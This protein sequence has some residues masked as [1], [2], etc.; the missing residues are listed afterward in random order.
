MFHLFKHRKA[1]D[2]IKEQFDNIEKEINTL[3]KRHKSFDLIR[4]GAFIDLIENNLDRF[5]KELDEFAEEE[6]E[7]IGFR[8]AFD[9]VINDTVIKAKVLADDLKKS[10]SAYK[11]DL[12]SEPRDEDRIAILQLIG[13]EEAK[14][15]ALGDSYRKSREEE[16]RKFTAE[17]MAKSTTSGPIGDTEGV[18]WRDIEKIIRQ[19]GGSIES[20]RGHSWTISFP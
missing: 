8:P 17:N 12:K 15:K 20:A 16:L 10:L 6:K 3:T 13:E 7:F 1:N 19:S 2:I 18:A 9:S 5:K 4:T 14:F 11:N